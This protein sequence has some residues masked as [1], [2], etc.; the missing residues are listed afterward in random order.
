MQSRDQRYRERLLPYDYK[1]QNG[2][3]TWNMDY[4]KYAHLLPSV[5]HVNTVIIML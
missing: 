5:M 2:K 3:Y 4:I 1:N